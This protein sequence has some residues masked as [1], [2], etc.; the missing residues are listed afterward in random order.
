MFLS[1]IVM[2]KNRRSSKP[3]CFALLGVRTLALQKLLSSGRG[4]EPYF[5]PGASLTLDLCVLSPR[6]HLSVPQEEGQRVGAL[7]PA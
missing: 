5:L 3:T 2:M 6:S 4:E 7:C 1:A